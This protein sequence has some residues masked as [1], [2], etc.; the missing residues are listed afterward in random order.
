MKYFFGVEN[1]SCVYEDGS[2][3][4][5]KHHLFWNPPLRNPQDISQGRQSFLE[6][7]V[8][9]CKYLTEQRI[10]FICFAKVGCSIEYAQILNFK[11]HIGK[12]NV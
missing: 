8:K 3:C 6:E 11:P 5:R 1:V 4:G 12:K 10:R 7:G 2:P 9:I